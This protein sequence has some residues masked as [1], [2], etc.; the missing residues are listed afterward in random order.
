MR[1]HKDPGKG[2]RR[3]LCFDRAVCCF[4]RTLVKISP[5]GSCLHP[6]QKRCDP[7]FQDDWLCELLGC[8]QRQCQISILDLSLRNNMVTLSRSY[9]PLHLFIAIIVSAPGLQNSNQVLT[10]F[11]FPFFVRQ[12]SIS[13]GCHGN[14]PIVCWLETKETYPS[15]RSR[16][17]LVT[18]WNQLGRK[19]A[20]NLWNQLSRKII[21]H[22]V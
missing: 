6:L 1:L 18:Q 2:H 17:P 9:Y 12:R 7:I 4:R 5:I 3:A 16:S 20:I 19:N 10:I 21:G 15:T 11:K 22:K 14:Q 13:T 8:R